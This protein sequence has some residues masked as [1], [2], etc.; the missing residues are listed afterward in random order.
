MPVGVAE[1]TGPGAVAL[2]A[3]LAVGAGD[4]EFSGFP[5]DV[6]LGLGA[7][8]AANDACERLEAAR[9]RAMEKAVPKI[10]DLFQNDRLDF[11]TLPSL[12]KPRK[13]PAFCHV[14]QE[15]QQQLS[16]QKPA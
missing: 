13:R 9:N 3:G 16:R 11:N 12:D 1:A 4:A 7:G 15:K 8:L 6:A 10:R 2:G 5:V 14:K